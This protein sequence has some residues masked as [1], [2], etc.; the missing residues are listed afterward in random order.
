MRRRS[1]EQHEFAP[2]ARYGSELVTHLV[3]IIMTRGK[4]STAQRTV[5]GALDEIREQSGEEPLDV[6]Q[7][8]LDNIKPKVEVKSLRVGGATYQVP[9]EVPASRQVSLALRWVV[10][11]SRGR[12]GTSMQRALANEIMDA[13]KGQG[14]ALKKRDDTHKMAAANKAFAHYRW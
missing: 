9:V 4:K 13:F 14:N 2:D 10:D 8:A 6:F 12:K 3:N 7:K 1:A 5:Y 11:Y